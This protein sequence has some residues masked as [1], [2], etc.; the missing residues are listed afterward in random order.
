M[1]RHDPRNNRGPAIGGGKNKVGEGVV[2]PCKTCPGSGNAQTES[3][4]E[5]KP[6][7]ACSEATRLW[8]HV[9]FG[10]A[11]CV[12]MIEGY[13]DLEMP[14]PPIADIRKLRDRLDQLIKTLE[15]KHA[16]ARPVE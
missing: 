5:S 4:P 7:T 10:T 16:T 1:P 12:G 9:T 2:K 3:K 15:A 11:T 6:V 13:A 8:R 14:N